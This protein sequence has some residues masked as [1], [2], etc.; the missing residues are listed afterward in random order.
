LVDSL[1]NLADA[2]REAARLA[3]IRGEPRV[4]EVGRGALSFP[5]A[6]PGGPVVPGGMMLLASPA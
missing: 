3:G 6:T 1:G 2:V 5:E 4:L